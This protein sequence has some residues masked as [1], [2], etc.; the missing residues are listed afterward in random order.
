MSLRNTILEH[1]RVQKSIS[2]LRSSKL[3][4]EALRKE[5]MAMHSARP[6]R[7]LQTKKLLTHSARIL[8]DA[9]TNDMTYRSRATEIKMLVL[10][11]KLD[12]DKIISA[13][14]KYILATFSKQLKKNFKTITEQKGYVEVLLDSYTTVSVDMNNLIAI[15]DLVMEDIDQSGWGLKRIEEVRASLQK[16]KYG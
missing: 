14:R 6:S 10:S 11:E 1:P 13:L 8:I 15:A 4:L 12:R 16:E 9:T 3:D 5:C 7:A 2:R